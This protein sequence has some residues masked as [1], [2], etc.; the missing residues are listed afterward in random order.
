LLEQHEFSLFLL[1]LPDIVWLTWFFSNSLSAQLLPKADPVRICVCVQ[2]SNGCHFTGAC[3]SFPAK[4]L[5]GSTP[6]QHAVFANAR[7]P[8]FFVQ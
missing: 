8:F 7:V 5:F 1:F 2:A 6:T 3:I 4:P